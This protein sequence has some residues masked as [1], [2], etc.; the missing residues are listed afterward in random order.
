MHL[1]RLADDPLSPFPPPDAAL[2]EPAGLLAWGGDLSVARLLQAYRQGIFPWF[3]DG[4]PILWWSPDPRMVL[5]THQM[6]LSR[7]LRRDLRGSD[8]RIAADSAFDAVVAACAQAPRPGQDGTWITGGMREAYRA[9][10][11]HGHAHSIEVRDPSGALVGGI[12]GVRIGRMFFGESM[13]SAQ[14]GGSKVALAGLCRA[15]AASGM[16]M[17]DCQVV[18]PHLRTLGA[19]AVSR[20][21]FLREVARLA[22][23]PAPTGWPGRCLPALARELA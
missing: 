3:S 1:P 13:F 17:L 20:C 14:P 4:Q 12:Y 5:R 23:E 16:P 2:S 19:V 10:H 6:H 18:S 15:M 21:E 9:L 22:A 7:R 11:A 8:W